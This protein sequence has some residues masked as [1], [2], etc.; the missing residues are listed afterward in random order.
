[1][2]LLYIIIGGAVGGGLGWLFDRATKRNE[3]KV[4]EEDCGTST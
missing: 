4:V 2:T 1:M 3:P